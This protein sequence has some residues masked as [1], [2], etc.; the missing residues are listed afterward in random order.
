[1]QADKTLE[2]LNSVVEINAMLDKNA[3]ATKQ[4]NDAS[5]KSQLAAQD[6]KEV[7]GRML[8]AMEEIER[9]NSEIMEEISRNNEDIETIINFIG[10]IGEKTRVINDIVFQT[11]LLSF[12]ASVEAARAG[13]QGKGF[14][15]V[16]EEVGSL[17][18]MS[19]QAAL[20]ITDMLES[21]TRKAHE[22][23]ESSKEKLAQITARGKSKIEE[24]IKT[25][26]ICG[27]SLDDILGSA[28]TMD[29]I[30]QEITAACVEQG[31]GV[32]EISKAMRELD[33][34]TQENSIL[35][36]E[37]S[38]TATSLNEKASAL[39]QAVERL[40]IIINGARKV[41]KEREEENLF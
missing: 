2:T 7:V 4:S 35:A 24:G 17:A 11:K 31:I 36:K 9:S 10:E 34:I 12:N 40:D 26:Q 8:A 1:M 6:G 29:N 23:V 21:S 13:E 39:A 37:S 33:I 5:S 16:A 14:S 3:K 15:V 25:A 27:N 41:A 28:A 22:I 18:S 30:I 32:N 19:G 20:E 38:S